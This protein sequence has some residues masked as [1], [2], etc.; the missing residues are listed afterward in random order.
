M[1]D[2]KN[3]LANANDS[4]FAIPN[5][6]ISASNPW[7]PITNPTNHPRYIHRGEVIRSIKDPQ[8]FFDSPMTD[9]EWERLAASATVIEKLIRS[10]S[11]SGT[12]ESDNTSEEYGP[13]TAAMPDPTIYPSSKLEELIDVGTLP[14]HLKARAW[15]MLRRR[16]KAFGFDGRLGHLD[17]KVHIRTVDGQV[18]ISA[19]MYGASPEKRKIIEAQ[20][21][22]WFK[23]GV[24]EP[25]K[26]PW[27]APVVIAY[28]H[29]KPRFCVDY[30]K[31]N[32]TTMPDEFPI[33]HQART[34]F[35]Q[36]PPQ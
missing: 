22:R 32:A 24:I 19:P 12:D 23:Q 33:P 28:R 35:T 13:K 2:Q 31:L 17:A 11:E 30:R 34:R 6:L 25:S 14:E 5:L 21:E 8:E 3:L 26:S 29:S 27:S 10:Q 36:L 18:P 15:E 9:E 1:A 4:F 16:E 20:L 7:V